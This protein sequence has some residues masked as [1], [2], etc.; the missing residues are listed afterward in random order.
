MNA[1][2]KANKEFLLPTS[3]LSGCFLH[4]T[5]EEMALINKKKT[6]LLYEKGENLFKQGAFAPFV[7]Y[8]LEGLVKVYIQT[9][10]RRQINVNIA[11]AGDFLAFSSV[12]G[13]ETYNYS[14]MALKDSRICMIDKVALKEVLMRN[15]AFAMQITSRNYRVENQLLEIIKN[16]SYKQMRGKLATA[17]CY[18]SSEEFLSE[19]IFETL[20]RQD[21]ADFAGITQESAVKFLKELEREDLLKLEGKNISITNREKLKM[22]SKTG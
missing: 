4:L 2:E 10:A 14:A 8:V 9:G 13:N 5:E 12:F 19:N 3:E 6:Q 11:R 20:T 16:L 21:I 18:L 17:L 15:S 7:L 1:M 22:I